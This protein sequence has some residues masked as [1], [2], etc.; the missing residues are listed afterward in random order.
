MF[1]VIIRVCAPVYLLLALGAVRCAAQT[2]ADF[3]DDSVLH[4][5]RLEIRR[6][7]W[8]ALKDHFRENTYYPANVEWRGMRLEGIAIRSRGRGSRSP[9]K[10]NLRVDINRYDDNQKFLGLKAFHLKANNQDPSFLKERLATSL[11]RRMG[12]L[13]SREANTRLYVNGEYVG[14]YL[15]VEEINK[16]F[17]QSNVGEDGG[18]LY[19]FKPTDDPYHFEYLGSDLT[20]YSPAPFDPQ[21]HEKD[22]NPRALEA[23]TRTLNQASNTEFP[24]AISA[25]LD[26]KLFVT[27]LGTE[28]FLADIDG[29][30]GDVLGANNFMLY[31]FSGKSL[32]RFIAWDK[33]LTFSSPDRDI[34]QNTNASVLMRRALTIPEV[35]E[36]YL[37][38]LARSQVLAGGPDGWLDQQ[39]AR[40]YDLIRGAAYDD[41][42]K[43][44]IAN[45]F[46]KPSSNDIFDAE[47]ARVTDFARQRSASVARQ[48]ALA[49]YRVSPSAP[50]LGDRA[51]VNIA[52][53]DTSVLVP[54][55]SVSLVGDR[56]SSTT[57]QADLSLPLPNSLGGASV[58]IN[59]FPA[60]LLFVSPA[61]I[62]LQV[63]FQIR[64]GTLP[65]TVVADGLV[66]NTIT[67]GAAS[68]GGAPAVSP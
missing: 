48:L 35:R 64:P 62:D 24:D 22:P 32:S 55:S 53:G 5:V 17:L 51:V 56:L 21:T 23:M 61:R 28:G 15:I 29:I 27:H 31:T 20:N 1:R 59:G 45:G 41:P 60:P 16:E 46:L 14:L 43:T 58:Y 37:A 63:P 10:P 13:A 68:P 57:A 36:A 6:S 34:W 42:F 2:Q 38:A 26:L 65:L 39:I 25:Y 3:F 11:F 67:V 7:D 8:Q 9:L 50:A 30:L 40:D 49:G 33:D 4:E 44:Y 54:G 47:V 18:Y 66:G 12:M 19:E 52:T